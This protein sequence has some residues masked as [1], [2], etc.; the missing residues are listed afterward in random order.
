MCAPEK[1]LWE[2]NPKTPGTWI[3]NVCCGIVNRGIAAWNGKIYIGTLDGRLVAIDAKTGREAW[4][5]LT[6]DQSKHYAITSA[7]RIAKGKVLIGESGGEFGVRG[8]LSAYDAE[9]GK[10]DWRFYTVPE[11]T[12]GPFENAVM[13]KAAATWSAEG[14][15]LGGGGT[16]WDSIVYDQVTDLIYFG[17]GNGSPWNDH[18][19]DPSTGDNLY[20]AS[21]IALKPDTGEY[22]WHYQTVPADTWDYDATSQMTL[23]NLTIGGKTAAGHHAAEQEWPVLRARRCEGHVVSRD[24]VHRCQLDGRR[25]HEDRPAAR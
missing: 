1:T 5:V 10:M 15:K 21:I 9:T 11:N 8:Y 22:V 23:A 2:Y 18:Y 13:K 20:L 12:T 3:R 19:R 14:L 17:T 25:R 7:P 4:S 6:I 16:V 24:S